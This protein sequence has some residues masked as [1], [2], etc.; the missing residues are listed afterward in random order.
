MSYDVIVVGGRLAGA[1]TGMLL[2]REGLSV[3]I[4]DRAH[5][6]SDTLSS[7]QLQPPGAARLR[8]WGLLDRLEA[9]GTPPVPDVRFDVDGVVIAGRYPEVDGSGALYS[10]RREVLDTLL[11]QAAREA[12]ADVRED[13]IV[14]ELL[15]TDGRVRGIRS[16]H[17]GSSTATD[18]TAALVVGAD[19][20]HSMVAKTVRAPSRRSRAARSLGFYCYWR[21]VEITA[22]EIYSRDRRVAGAWPTDDGMIVTYVGWPASEFEVFRTDPAGHVRQ[23]LDDCGT[24]GA[25]IR[26]GRQVGPVRGTSDLPNEIRVSAGPGWALAGDAGLV[27][28]PITGQGMG[29]ALRDADLLSD[30]I[31]TGLGGGRLDR[32]L[33]RYV[34]QRDAET[35][36]MFDFTVRLASFPPPT[37][38][39]RAMFSAIAER[40]EETSQFFGALAGSVPVT[41]L[42]SPRRLMAMTGVR[43]FAALARSQ[44]RPATPRPAPVEELPDPVA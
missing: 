14:D 33:A 42:F 31:V 9:T 22:G 21:D 20:K 3:L 32:S 6:P 39:E 18:D 35:K 10:P 40:P 17:K 5:F 7:H 29:H 43:G 25:R 19:G 8:R 13:T 34:K 1:A 11:V 30:A 4:V 12:G 24:L 41:S 44:L 23:T 38:A 36:P 2:A 37:T 28:D 15:L 26:A 16:R 27:M